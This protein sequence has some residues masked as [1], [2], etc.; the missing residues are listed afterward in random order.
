MRARHEGA[1]RVWFGV[2]AASLG[3]VSPA[4]ADSPL[5][6]VWQAPDECPSGPGV[7]R[8]VERLITKPPALALPATVVVRKRDERFT[9]EIRT[10]GGSR[11][12]EGESCRAVGE[13][14]AMVL[15]LAI[16]PDATPN[17]DA[18]AAFDE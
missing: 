3:V 4:R 18:F 9:A 12:L 6:L 1:L 8:A 14:V 17:A 7:T 5:V 13:A 16:D 11:H 2:L 10:S 15:A